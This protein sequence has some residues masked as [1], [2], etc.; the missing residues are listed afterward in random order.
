MNNPQPTNPTTSYNDCLN[1]AL[2][3]TNWTKAYTEFQ[4]AFGLI[5][6]EIPGA[7][8]NDLR[9]EFTN[10]S[11]ITF[12]KQN[13]NNIPASSPSDKQNYISF[14][15]FPS[16][17]GMVKPSPKTRNQKEKQKKGNLKN[18]NGSK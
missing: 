9:P 7:I 2:K 18:P 16:T 11:V 5:V 15:P 8:I 1:M 6:V 4:K 12:G 3:F 17:S 14:K 10:E 13:N